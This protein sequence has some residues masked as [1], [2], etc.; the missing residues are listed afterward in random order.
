[1]N[2]ETTS[3]KQEGFTI[4]ELVI[5]MVLI[6]IVI[7]IIT[8]MLQLLIQMNHRTSNV[9]NI[10][11]LV[12]NKTE[13]LR[14]QGFNAIGEPGSTHEFN[15]DIPQS[16]PTPRSA[17]YTISVDPLKPSEKIVDFKIIVGG[18]SYYY[19][20]LIGELGVGQF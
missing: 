8:G 5:G 1:M 17:S 20:T 18:K 16:I 15:A 2:A 10:S 13:S 14:S 11:S 7:L 9:V 19:K 12:Q 6:G 4:V 3:E